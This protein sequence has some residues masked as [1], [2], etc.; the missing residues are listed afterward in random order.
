[1]NIDHLALADGPTPETVAVAGPL[2][3]DLDSRREAPLHVTDTSGCPVDRSIAAVLETRLGVLD[4]AVEPFRLTEL[5]ARLTGDD[6]DGQLLDL[7]EL[8]LCAAW[9]EAHAATY[10]GLLG[11]TH[12]VTA[13]V[14]GTGSAGLGPPFKAPFTMHRSEPRTADA[15]AAI[16]AYLRR[17][18]YTWMLAVQHVLGPW[19]R[20]TGISALSLSAE[21]TVGAGPE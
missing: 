13:G 2:I 18:G 6:A 1:M 11:R 5:H 7:Q 4:A 15:E 14:R 16:Q 12:R 17:A 20:D 21:L 19:M 9:L 3:L 10:P 8:S